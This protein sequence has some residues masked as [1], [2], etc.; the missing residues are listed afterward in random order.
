[1]SE[2]EVFSKLGPIKECPICGGELDKGYI[3]ASGGVTWDAKKSK[4][5][6]VYMWSAAL[7]LPFYTQN[8]PALRC[9]NCELVLFHYG[10]GISQKTSKNYLKKCVTC[11]KE[12]PIASEE[13][14]N[15]EAKQPEYVKP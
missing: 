3:G 10:K 2:S 7:M 5:L 8:I 1:M 14:P 12:I 15:C 11:G 9:K 13:C 6:F 4:R